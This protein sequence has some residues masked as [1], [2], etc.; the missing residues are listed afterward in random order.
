MLESVGTLKPLTDVANFAQSVPKM[1]SRI[2]TA[3]NIT[4]EIGDIQ[5]YGVND[6]ETF[7][8][9]LMDTLKNNKNITKIIQADT[10]GIMTGKS[11]LSKFKY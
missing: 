11:P 9:Q 3:H 6:P 4:V 2:N 10:L 8:A 7:A 1:L 5:M